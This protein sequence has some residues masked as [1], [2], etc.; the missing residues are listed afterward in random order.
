VGQQHLAFE[1][2][3]EN[4]TAHH[5]QRVG[6]GKVLFL[7]GIILSVCSHEAA[8]GTNDQFRSRS[9]LSAE[10]RCALLHRVI[11][12]ADMGYIHVSWQ[13]RERASGQLRSMH[14]L[15]NVL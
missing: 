7:S 6:N 8:C 12:D 2:L 9:G 1:L 15:C 3:L 13:R 11:K 10:V 5:H 14:C 4:Q